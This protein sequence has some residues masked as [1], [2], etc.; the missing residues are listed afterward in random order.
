MKE[1][2]MK[3]GSVMLDVEALELTAQDKDLL[4]HPQCGGVI[5]FARNFANHEQV[6]HLADSVRALRN[7]E[8][9]I[10]VDQEGGR[11]QRFRN[12]FFALPPLG[13]IG[14]LFQQDPEKAL[15]QA[16][17]FAWLM[18]SECLAVGIDFSFAPVLDLNFGV[19]EVIGNR[20]FHEDPE[21]V[22][23]LADAY[24]HGLHQAGM[25]AVGKHY[26]GHGFVHADSH[27]DLPV[28]E[29]KFSQ[30]EAQDLIPFKVLI[31]RGIEALMPAH[32]VYQACDNT[33]AGFSSF[34]L[35]DILRKRL[36]FEGVIFS[37]DLS[38]TAAESIGSPADRAEAALSAGC[39]MLLVCND[40]NAAG[41]VLESLEGKNFPESRRRIER[42]RRHKRPEWQELHASNAWAKA[43]STVG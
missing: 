17:C 27:K 10:A 40:P 11:V 39:D 32:V 22:A 4:L 35:Q 21:A 29:R 28:D 34:W 36:E 25:A 41:Q 3:L 8:L 9:L 43:V 12:G 30:I 37:D 19:S 23:A 14:E 1:N 7:P 18:A 42:M 6:K 16:E 13:E 20:A 24:M 5:F 33:P 31:E 2:Q 15:Q 26:P 38:M